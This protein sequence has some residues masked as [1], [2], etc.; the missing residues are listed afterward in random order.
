MLTVVIILVCLIPCGLLLWRLS[1][2]LAERNAWTRL[3][4]LSNGAAVAFDPKTVKDLPD[5]ARRFFLYTFSEGASLH[6]NT[7]L[8]MTGELSLG[9]KDAPDYRPMQ[10][11][12]ILAP[13]YGLVWRLKFGAISG[14]D[15]LLPETSWTRFWVFHLLPV[16][17]VGRARDHQLSAFGRLIA[18]SA[19][20][21]PAALLPGKDIT[22]EPVDDQIA[23]AICHFQGFEQSVEITVD[24]DGRPSHVVIDRWSNENPEHLF[25]RQPFGGTLSCFR[26][27]DGVRLP[28]YVEGG[29]HFGTEDYFPFYKARILSVSFDATGPKSG[30]GSS[31]T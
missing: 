16:V 11:R 17:R 19:F 14:S 23:R 18:E 6:R 29:N 27:F 15:V 12:Q 3:A 1:D 24:P 2:V 20:W 8:T 31:A 25:R 26:D 7:V 4:D 21:A 5:P 9:R 28:T 13:P 30:A 10:A 22:W